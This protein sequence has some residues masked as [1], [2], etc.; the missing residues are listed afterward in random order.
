MDRD[1]ETKNSDWTVQVTDGFVSLVESLKAKTTGPA[2]RI[3]H[4]IVHA[5]II[6]T[7]GIS[8]LTLLVIGSIRLVNAYLPGDV[9]AAHLLLGALFC[10]IGFIFWSK[11]RP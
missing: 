9:W 2:L 5:F 7:V 10:S 8:V 11:R 1:T 3:V 4:A 6:I